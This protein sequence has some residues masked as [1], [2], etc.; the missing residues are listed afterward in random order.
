MS[1]PAAPQRPRRFGDLG[2]R[3][4]VLAA[5]LVGL[6]VA[7]TVGF[8]GLAALARTDAATERVYTEDLLGFERVAAVRRATLE[9]RLAVT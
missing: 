9:M 6:V 4:R 5:V 1:R 2:V 8:S 3:T 7:G